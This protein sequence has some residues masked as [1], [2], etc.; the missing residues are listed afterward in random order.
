MIMV[1]VMVMVMVMIEVLVI[2]KYEWENIEGGKSTENQGGK[3]TGFPREQEWISSGVRMGRD[4]TR[5]SRLLWPTL[6]LCRGINVPHLK[7][8]M[9][10]VIFKERKILC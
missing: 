2:G 6:H 4:F 3:K 9:L 1:D 5:I 10:S 8:I 7:N